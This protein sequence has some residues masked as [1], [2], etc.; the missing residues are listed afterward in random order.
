[1]RHHTG[2]LPSARPRLRAAAAAILLFSALA[3]TGCG[4]DSHS[5]GD[6]PIDLTKLD[7][8]NYQ[9]KPQDFSPK[10]ATAAARAA[11][12]LRLGDIM[13]LPM[14]ID[15]A[16]T[17]NAFGDHV[18]LS[19]ET[20][21][22]YLNVDHFDTDAPGFVAGFATAAQTTP[23]SGLRSLS[24]AVM[25]FDSD[26]DAATAA[27]ALARTGL[28]LKPIP[29]AGITGETTPLQ[30]TQHPNAQI[31][32]SSQEQILASWY[33]TGR[34]VIFTLIHQSENSYLQSYW[35]VAPDPAPLAL[36]DKAIDVTADRLK[37][38][39]PTP[40]DKLAGLPL[41]PDGM[42]RLTLPRPD[43]D[44]TA[45]AFTGTL[46]EHGALHDEV[47]PAVSRALFDKAGID[48]VSY[49][50]GQL[51]RARDADSARAFLDTAY[52]D[53]VRHPIASPPGLPNAQCTQYRGP[54]LHKFPF[55]CHVTFGRYVA[56]VWSQQQQDVYQ[57]ISAQY[58]ILANSK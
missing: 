58:A 16:L 39:E 18:L 49:G 15:P 5:P 53:Q 34:F 41:D 25:I 24:D 27:G 45:N 6:Q 21:G 51:N 31:R 8:G 44:Q 35:H 33:P 40:A 1:M 56:S 26:A 46:D 11:E 55:D 23:V 47:D 48:R 7:T 3:A 57:R 12:A 22:G 54:D 52:V 14:E 10:D 4:S 2:R 17:T 43:G 20:F 50:A 9:T 38:F 19:G 28:D 42:L 13:P 32:W 36:A 30:S 37:S 29:S